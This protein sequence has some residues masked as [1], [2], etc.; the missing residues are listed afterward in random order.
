M[1]VVLVV[2]L[3]SVPFAVF[4]A[5]SNGYMGEAE[6][7]VGSIGQGRIME[8]VIAQLDASGLNSAEILDHINQL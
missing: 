2:L 7:S 4:A 5:S 8:I 3:V 1:V 6:V